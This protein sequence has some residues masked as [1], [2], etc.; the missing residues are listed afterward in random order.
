[1]MDYPIKIN[2]DYTSNIYQATKWLNKLPELFAADFEIASKFSAEQK[3]L[4]KYRL[5]HNNLTFE[6]RRVLQQQINSNGFSHPSLTVITHLSIAWSDRDSFVIVCNT[7]AV[8]KLVTNFLVTSLSTQIWHNA[9]FDFSHIYYNTKQLP[10]NYIDTQL[11]A[12]TLL[13]NADSFKDRTGLKTLMAY[14]YGDWAVSKDD[15]V[16]EEM[17]DTNMICYSATD[18]CATYRLYQD[19]KSDLE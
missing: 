16:L 13:N 12:K 11:L 6:E 18:S 19:I 2:Y 4:L 1:M 9:V 10:K 15:F 5:A 14:A 17:W 3:E 8:R 7:D